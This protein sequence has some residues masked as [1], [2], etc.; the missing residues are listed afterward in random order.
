[1]KWGAE[2]VTRFILTL[3]VL[4]QSCWFCCAG[5]KLQCNF[6]TTL[7]LQLHKKKFIYC[8]VI[9]NIDLVLTDSTRS[10]NISWIKHEFDPKSHSSV[11]SC[12]KCLHKGSILLI[13][14]MHSLKE[15]CLVLYLGASQSS[16][17]ISGSSWNVHG[18]GAISQKWEKNK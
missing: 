16:L 6:I 1:M 2:H 13:C 15:C 18:G 10:C 5:C 17:S 12:L 7:I 14:N 8:I 3:C 9:L 11:S 4:W